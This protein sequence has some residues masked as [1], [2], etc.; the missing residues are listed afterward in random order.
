MIDW[1][2]TQTAH[3]PPLVD[4]I[5]GMSAMDDMDKCGFADVSI[6]TKLMPE[7]W[8]MVA[9]NVPPEAYQ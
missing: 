7:Q 8:I 6:R 4:R 2:S 5:A 1:V 9:Q 3:G